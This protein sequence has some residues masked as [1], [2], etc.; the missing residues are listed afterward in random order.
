LDIHTK[1]R[2]FEQQLSVFEK[3][4]QNELA[5]FKRK[6]AI[7][8]QLHQ[9][10]TQLLLEELAKL[11]NAVERETASPAPTQPVANSKT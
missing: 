9:D 3:L 5:E 8:Q 11:K 1:I 4:H 2:R 6:L 10:E 7:Y